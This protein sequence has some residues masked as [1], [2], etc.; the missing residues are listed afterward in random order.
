MM[1][2]KQNIALGQYTL[3]SSVALAARVGFHPAAAGLDFADRNLQRNTQPVGMALT[4]IGPIP[5]GNMQ[6]V[7]D[8]DGVEGGCG[9]GIPISRQRIEQRNTVRP[10]RECHPP[11]GRL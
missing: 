1:R 3:E 5:R 6:T 4:E 2:G 7:V 9:C 10:T 8:V 11:A